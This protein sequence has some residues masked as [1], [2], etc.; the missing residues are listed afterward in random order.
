[1]YWDAHA[2]HAVPP[3]SPSIHRLLFGTV[4]STAN[5]TV[6]LMHSSVASTGCRIASAKQM[7]NLIIGLTESDNLFVSSRGCYLHSLP[8]ALANCI[9]ELPDRRCIL[10]NM[11]AIYKINFYI[12]IHLSIIAWHEILEVFNLQHA[13][14]A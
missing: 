11:L 4:E 5:E 1:M 10:A 9:D 3:P 2:V 14:D 13:Y 7:H 8:A 6:R 12:N